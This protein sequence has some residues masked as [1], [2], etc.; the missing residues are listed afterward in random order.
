[1][2]TGKPQVGRTPFDRGLTGQVRNNAGLIGRVLLGVFIWLCFAKV[3]AT[4]LGDDG[5]MSFEAVLS[6]GA[7][8]HLQWGRDL[9][10]TYGPLGVLI[11]DYY[12][13]EFFLVCRFRRRRC[14][15]PMS[16][17]LPPGHFSRFR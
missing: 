17:R 4:T 8:H 5:A 13:G 16:P 10:F 1:M 14:L 6:F 11:S 7:A 9:I 12:W 3:P 2:H 15:Q